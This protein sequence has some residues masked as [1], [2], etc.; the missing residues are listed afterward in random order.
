VDGAS[1]LTKFDHEL[2]PFIRVPW[3][4]V[5][6]A[7]E[8]DDYQRNQVPEGKQLRV[9]VAEGP[10]SVRAYPYR[11]IRDIHVCHGCGLGGRDRIRSSDS[12]V[13][14]G[15]DDDRSSSTQRNVGRRP[16]NVVRDSDGDDRC[17][18]G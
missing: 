16:L 18:K 3:I 1:E 14:V 9:N 17:A 10:S 4:W 8:C 5:R 2:F 13:H 11:L 6:P 15:P 7:K 12:P